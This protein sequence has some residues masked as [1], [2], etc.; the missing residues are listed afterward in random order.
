MNK[1]ADFIR[2]PGD[3]KVTGSAEVK[4]PPHIAKKKVDYEFSYLGKTRKPKPDKY[5]FPGSF[6]KANTKLAAVSQASL[7]HQ[8]NRVSMNAPQK[9]GLPPEQ[10]VIANISDMKLHDGGLVTAS[11]TEALDQ[12]NKL[13]TLKP[14][15][16]DKLQVLSEY[17]INQN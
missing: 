10:F 3:F 6:F 8:N 12:Y 7:S 2:L 5:K 16:R 13:I 1:R 4:A 9:V 11:Y 17:E 14:E 15:L